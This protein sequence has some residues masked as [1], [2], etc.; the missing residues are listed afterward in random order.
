MMSPYLVSFHY[1]EPAHMYMYDYLLYDV[2]RHPELEKPANAK[3]G[4]R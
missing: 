1:M 4:K 3:K 2:V